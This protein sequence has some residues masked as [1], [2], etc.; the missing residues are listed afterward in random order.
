MTI[1]LTTTTPH[2][3]P[4]P[5]PFPFNQRSFCVYEPIEKRIERIRVL[6]INDLIHDEADLSDTAIRELGRGVAARVNRERMIGKLAVGNILNNID[7]LVQKPETRVA[8]FSEIERVAEEFEPQAIVLSGTLS[9]FDWYH[10]ALLEGFAEFITRTQ[11]P[12]LAIC[13]GH[14]LVGLSF[15]AKVVTLDN[16]EQWEQRARRLYEYQYRFV[17]ITAP[18]DPIFCGILDEHSGVWQDYTK[19]ARILRVWQNHGLQLDRVPE[20]FELLASSYLCKN[21]MMMRRNDDQLIYAVQFHLEKSFEDY[22]TS[23]THGGTRWEHVNESRDGRIIF[24]N[25]MRA[26]LDREGVAG[27]ACEHRQPE[28]ASVSSL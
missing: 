19:E 11:T 7:R 25:F 27:Y 17:R 26:A 15:G 1:E 14:Q 8:H 21:Q 9:D 3:Q 2:D 12:T 24:E 28:L 6:V 20:G 4:E 13:G 16:L 23:R 10:P 18:E 5:L 22:D